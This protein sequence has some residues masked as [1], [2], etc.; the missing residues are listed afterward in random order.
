MKITQI[1]RHNLSFNAIQK[2]DWAQ[3]MEEQSIND[4]RSRDLT[5]ALFYSTS[6]ISQNQIN[7]IHIFSKFKDFKMLNP[8]E[9][10]AYYAVLINRY[11]GRT[12][13]QIP[14]F[15]DKQNQ[16]Q[17]RNLLLNYTYHDLDVGYVQGMNFIA[18]TLVYF[19][20]PQNQKIFNELIYKHRNI[21]IAGTPGLFENLALLKFKLK[22]KIPKLF[23]YLQ[24]I[25]LNDFGIC[26]SSYYLTMMLQNTSFQYQMLILN[27]YQLMGQKYMTKLLI[28]MLK[29]SKNTIMKLKDVENVNKYI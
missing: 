27:I 22:A 11:V 12:Y 26:F 8:Q 29:L 10:S 14:Y 5:L 19:Q 13:Q 24:E 3:I 20:V 9:P 1:P 23:K 21:Y 18:G 16:D 25:G 17:I 7:L 15:K 28:A 2:E 6:L 4:F